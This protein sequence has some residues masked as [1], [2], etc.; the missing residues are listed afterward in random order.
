[1]AYEEMESGVAR[2]NS[3]EEILTLR[4]EWRVRLAVE[5]RELEERRRKERE[6]EA[7]RREEEDKRE[8]LLHRARSFRVMYEK[9]LEQFSDSYFGTQGVFKS[10]NEFQKEALADICETRCR[11][12]LWSA[13]GLFVPMLFM[14]LYAYLHAQEAVQFLSCRRWL[15][16][17]AKDSSLQEIVREEPS[18]GQWKCRL[19]RKSIYW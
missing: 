8:I 4:K 14:K 5:K 18:H 17:V 9:L 13:A 15:R 10:L 1:M 12:G 3:R 6:Q 7:L 2:Q 11:W 16:R 19:G